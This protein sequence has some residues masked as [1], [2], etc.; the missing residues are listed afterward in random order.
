MKLKIY[1]KRTL[2][3]L[4][5]VIA[6]VLFIGFTQNRFDNN[7]IRI[8]GFYLEEKNSL[9]VVLLGASEVYTDFS[10]AMAYDEYG[11]TSYPYAIESNPLAL[12]KSQI[13]EIL[14]YQTPKL[15]VIEMNTAASYGEGKDISV[16]NDVNLRRYTDN[17][18]LSQNKI[19]TVNE[20]SGEDDMLSYYLPFIK[21]HGDP[22]NFYRCFYETRMN[23]T[24][25]S[26]LKG[27]STK[28]EKS[29]GDG[30]YNLQG[31]TSTAELI[32]EYEKELREFL[33]FCKEENLDNVLFVRFPHRVT[34]DKR[35]QRFQ[36]GNRVG[37]IISQYG[38]DYLNFENSYEA[39]DLDF[40]N[41]FYND[42]HMNIYG[43]QKFTEYFGRI[44]QN[45]YGIQKSGISSDVKK[46]WDE[47]VDYTKRL[48][49]YVGS[50]TESGND[51]WIYETSYLLF[52]LD[53]VEQQ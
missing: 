24:G 46:K 21:Y 25:Y 17:M 8:D 3:I 42:D 2:K 16:V 48:Y 15:F 19:D 1:G 31:D 22:L 28:T 49:K 10:S 47:S 50:L 32:P 33:D 23:F 6:V 9:D 37:E 29:P 11:F 43:Q 7:K 14:N 51:R 34:N 5:L 53:N 12:Y 20:F 4:S 52:E 26:L 45:D 36:R 44:L 41:D 27:V 18:P 39:F 30:A 38:Y 40:N 13:K 35:Y